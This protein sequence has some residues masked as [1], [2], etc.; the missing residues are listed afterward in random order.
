MSSKKYSFK[1]VGETPDE[2][3]QRARQSIS[4]PPIGIV[5]PMSLGEGDD[6]IFKMHHDLGNT[7]ADNL[8]NLI[9]TNWGERLMD[10]RFGA[11]LRELTFELGSEDTDAVAIARIKAATDRYLPYVSLDTFEPF[12]ELVEESGIARI[13]VRI[14]YTV[15]LV[16]TKTRSLEVTLHTAG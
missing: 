6:G 1:A 8:R 2:L 11:N 13:G 9:L 12:N 3:A 7:I 16:D 5:T 10:Y 4:S 15:P 14:T